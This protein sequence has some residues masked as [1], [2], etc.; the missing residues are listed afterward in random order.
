MS[1]SSWVGSVWGLRGEEGSVIGQ[2]RAV[3]GESLILT[4]VGLG[5]K[6]REGVEIVSSREGRGGYARVSVGSLLARWDRMSGGLARFLA[7]PHHDAA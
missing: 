5:E 4:V 3:D 2:V 7:V 1:I 6:A